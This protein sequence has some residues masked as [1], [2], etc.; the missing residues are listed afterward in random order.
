MEKFRV[1][2]AAMQHLKVHPTGQ[3]ANACM[4][5]HCEQ[6]V[7]NVWVTVIGRSTRSLS[8]H[9][10]L[11]KLHRL[12]RHSFQPLLGLRRKRCRDGSGAPHWVERPFFI[13]A[14]VRRGAFAIA[15]PKAI[16]GE[17]SCCFVGR[18]PLACG[19]ATVIMPTFNRGGASR[20]AR[21][22]DVSGDM[23]S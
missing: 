15:F 8:V 3:K 9:Q 16:R 6:A 11:A 13:P 10:L 1:D 21:I 5:L 2:V 12:G 19:S 14:D 17:T 18:L 7:D 22:I 20:R 23:G 4:G